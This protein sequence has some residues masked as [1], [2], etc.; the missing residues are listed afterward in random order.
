[1]GD[2]ILLEIVAGDNPHRQIRNTLTS[3]P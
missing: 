2:F 1:L 3:R